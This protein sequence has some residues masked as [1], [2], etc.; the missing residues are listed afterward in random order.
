MPSLYRHNHSHLVGTALYKTAISRRFL[1]LAILRFH[2]NGLRAVVQ[3]GETHMNCALAKCGY[4]K[5]ALDKAK[6]P[7]PHKTNGSGDK[8]PS[9]GHVVIPYIKGTSEAIRRTFSGY[10][11]SVFFQPTRTLR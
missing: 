2:D 9:K 11:I 8:T 1:L 10:G 7:K 5:W 4:L 6:E 3:K